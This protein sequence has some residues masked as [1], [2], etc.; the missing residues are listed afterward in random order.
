MQF[1]PEHRELILVGRTSER[2]GKRRHAL[3]EANPDDIIA[4]RSGEARIQD[5]LPYLTPDEREFLI[6]GMTPDEWEYPPAKKKRK[7]SN[8]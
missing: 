7:R 3:I 8:C 4:W 6:T 1:P 2:S 5:A